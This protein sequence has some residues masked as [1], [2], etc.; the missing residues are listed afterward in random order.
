LKRK[1]VLAVLVLA[2]LSAAFWFGSDTSWNLFPADFLGYYENH[3]QRLLQGKLDVE[4]SSIEWEAFQKDGRSYGY[5]GPVPALMRI[6]WSSLAP[7]HAY[8]WTLVSTLS[9][10]LVTLLLVKRVIA[11]TL[12]GLTGLPGSE[13]AFVE[14]LLLTNI[15]LGST[16]S[17]LSSPAFIYNEA[18]LW[19]SAFALA[20]ALFLLLYLQSASRKY[21]WLALTTAFLAVQTRTSSGFGSLI[22]LLLVFGGALAVRRFRSARTEIVHRDLLPDA[23]TRS[24]RLNLVLAISVVA[25]AATPGAWNWLKFREFS[26]YPY[27]YYTGISPEREARTGKNFLQPG[28]L[29][30]NGK[31]YLDPTALSRSDVFPYLTL[32]PKRWGWR[33]ARHVHFDIG[34]PFVPVTA[35]MMLWVV[36]SVAG[37]VGVL[38]GLPR[39]RIRCPVLVGT[40]AGGGV[41]FVLAAITPRYIHDLF[42]FLVLSGITGLVWLGRMTFRWRAVCYGAASLMT[43]FSVYLN[44][45]FCFL[46]PLAGPGLKNELTLIRARLDGQATRVPVVDITGPNATTGIITGD[47]RGRWGVVLPKQIP[48]GLAIGS[49]LNFATSG[50]RRIV[51]VQSS[52]DFTVAMVD[53]RLVPSGDGAPF[54]VEYR[55]IPCA[56][57]DC[58]VSRED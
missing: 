32:A 11:L 2:S 10:I 54:A 55:S 35:S 19:G 15:A 41:I 21:A 7:R 4:F 20:S 6:V 12:D 23:V 48:V 51:D 24:A 39:M 3:G 38:K 52:E 34:E 22:S 43:V 57:P 53:G 8:H 29:L 56:T 37:A 13:R 17:T 47:N 9:A 42:P 44:T 25:I 31:H 30:F 28:N 18:V 27:K 58:D 14:A 49:W 46:N 5:F 1:A 36:L 45:A 16:L 33:T 26:A 50:E 40:L